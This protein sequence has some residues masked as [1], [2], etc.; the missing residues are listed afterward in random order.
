MTL[1]V[2]A[3][4]PSHRA[5]GPQPD[6]SCSGLMWRDQPSTQADGQALH[7]NCSWSAGLSC[8]TTPAAKALVL[9]IP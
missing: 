3:P 6:S 4:V 8:V 7:A 9:P 5:V 2:L 1:K